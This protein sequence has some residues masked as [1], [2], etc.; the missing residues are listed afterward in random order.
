M[1][2]TH[3]LALRA[4][5]RKVL[6]YLLAG[7]LSLGLDILTDS[8]FGF[9]SYS[10]NAMELP[11]L[12]LFPAICLAVLMSRLIIDFKA[13][14]VWLPLSFGLKIISSDNRAGNLSRRAV[15]R[16]H[17]PVL[18]TLGSFCILELVGIVL[19]AAQGGL[20][21]SSN[22][23]DDSVAM[24]TEKIFRLT[25]SVSMLDVLVYAFIIWCLMDLSWILISGVKGNSVRGLTE[26]ISGTKYVEKSAP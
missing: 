18:L 22:H 1:N 19:Y 14:N 7:V 15:V 17:L 11:F 21:S 8:E 9:I 3:K 2:A 25:E 5:S 24:M 16:C 26:A 13:T 4:V 20:Y 23:L 6:M 12:G 10:S